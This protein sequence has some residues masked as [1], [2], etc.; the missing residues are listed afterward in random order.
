[1]WPFKGEAK[2]GGAS[3][4]SQEERDLLKGILDEQR[5][6]KDPFHALNQ[7]PQAITKEAEDGTKEV[8]VPRVTVINVP[9]VKPVGFFDPMKLTKTLIALLLLGGVGITVVVA[10]IELFV[11]MNAGVVGAALTYIAGFYIFLAVAV[12]TIIY[13]VYDRIR[14]APVAKAYRKCINKPGKALMVLWRK[15]GV[16]SMED[17]RYVAETFEKDANPAKKE[18]PLAFFKTDNAPAI[19]G[20]A[21]V[22]VFYDAANVMAN[23]EFALACAEL[24]R[25]GYTNIEEAKKAYLD[26]TLRV[27]I[28]LFKE[29]DFGALYDFVKG[30]PAITKAYCDVKVNEARAERDMKIT[31]NPN[32]MMLGFLM[33]IGVI[34]L[35]LAKAFGLF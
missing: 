7:P 10:V 6:A 12:V 35:G 30:R 24:K 19:L 3:T 27:N 5:K 28:P 16:V 25:L 14:T 8:T 32:V 17:A 13:A 29:V 26:K 20:R 21:G 9:E 15:T 1:M 11:L 23:P 18:D 33:I 34:A 2:G 31:D 22:G 4:L